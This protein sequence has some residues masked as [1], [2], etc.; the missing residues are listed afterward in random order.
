MLLIQSMI[1]N[2]N[3]FLYNHTIPYTIPHMIYQSTYWYAGVLTLSFLMFQK[4]DSNLC[5]DIMSDKKY[6]PIDLYISIE[7][8]DEIYTLKY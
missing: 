3:S 2:F 5:C 6:K 7:S 4:L 8:K 1:S